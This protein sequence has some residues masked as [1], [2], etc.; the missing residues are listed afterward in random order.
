MS[1]FDD[2]LG[3]ILNDPDAMGQIMA[4]AQSLSQPRQPPQEGELPADCGVSET[5]FS[6]P[7]GGRDAEL[8]AALRPYLRPE[9]QRKLDRAL[10]LL[11]LIRLLKAGH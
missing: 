9:R 5:A 3:A 4:L 10:E 8:L 6:L 2:K 7:G 1:E 11:Q